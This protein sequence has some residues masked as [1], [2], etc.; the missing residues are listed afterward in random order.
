[1]RHPHRFVALALISGA[2]LMQSPAAWAQQSPYSLGQR[3]TEAQ[4]SGLGTLPSVQISGRSYRVLS[5]STSS[6]GLPLSHVLGPDGVVGQ[7]F[8]EV[9]I[10]EMAPH[11]ARQQFANVIAQAAAVQYQEHAELTILRFATLEQAAAAL[12]QIRATQPGVEA[13]LPISFSPIS[14]R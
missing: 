11:T 9:L 4:I 6:Q 14:P 10:A 13:G 3:L 2:R 12:L 7:T 5:T 8:H 1:M